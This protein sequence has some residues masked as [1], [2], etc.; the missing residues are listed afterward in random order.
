MLPRG[1]WIRW[2]STSNQL[3]FSGTWSTEAAY[4]QVTVNKVCDLLKDSERLEYID[5]YNIYIYLVTSCNCVRNLSQNMPQTQTM[6][7]FNVGCMIDHDWVKINTRTLRGNTN[8]K[9]WKAF[10]TKG[11]PSNLVHSVPMCPCPFILYLERVSLWTSNPTQWGDLQQLLGHQILQIPCSIEV[12]Q[13]K[14]SLSSIRS[15]INELRS[16]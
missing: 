9:F 1:Q 12:P 5:V 15:S 14:S 3:I 2:T 10:C 11:E 8:L 4:R 16:K 6:V 13:K 7:V